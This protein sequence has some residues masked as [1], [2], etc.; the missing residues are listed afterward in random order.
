MSHCLNKT[1]KAFVGVCTFSRQSSSLG[2]ILLLLPDA[3]SSW[4][5]NWQMALEC[6]FGILHWAH[7][8]IKLWPFQHLLFLNFALKN[9]NL[10]L[11][12]PELLGFGCFVSPLEGSQIREACVCANTIDNISRGYQSH[13]P[14]LSTARWY[15]DLGF[16][17]SLLAEEPRRVA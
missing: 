15:F 6:D 5:P 3:S 1:Q 9:L 17:Q 12:C 16:G 2:Q 10:A 7:N 4:Q 14:P 13:I 11:F 8:S